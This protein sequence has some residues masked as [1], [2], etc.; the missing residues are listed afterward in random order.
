MVAWVE[1]DQAAPLVGEASVLPR[2]N[3]SSA[4]AA[5]WPEPVAALC[6]LDHKPLDDGRSGAD[7]VA[8]KDVAD[9]QCDEIATTWLAIDCEIEHREIAHAIADLQPGA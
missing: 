9:S 1:P 4:M 8:G 5:A 7:T 2:G 3:M 6:S